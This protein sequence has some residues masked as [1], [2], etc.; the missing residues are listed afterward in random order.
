MDGEAAVAHA[1]AASA[2]ETRQ[3]ASARR[4]VMRPG[5][6]S[7]QR[8]LAEFEPIEKVLPMRR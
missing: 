8:V 1:D 5:S 6:L 7:A 4:I 3:A 2:I